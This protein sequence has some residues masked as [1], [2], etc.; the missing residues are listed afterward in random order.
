[1]LNINLNRNLNVN[2]NTRINTSL[3]GFVHNGD[4]TGARRMPL[5]KRKH[6]PTTTI[7]L[8]VPL[9]LKGELE[10]LR[11]LALKADVDFTASIGEMITAMF[12]SMRGEL[13]ALTGKGGHIN[14]TAS[15]T[16]EA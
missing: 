3:N 15:S 14:G 1:M 2:L 6:Q 9:P 12:K 7:T 4:H 5:V 11:K 8:R 13:E 10:A 16:K